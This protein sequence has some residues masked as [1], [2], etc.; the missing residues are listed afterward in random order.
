MKK[1]LF[2]VLGLGF[3]SVAFA[4]MSPEEK[5][6]LKAAQKEAKNQMSQGVKLST[7]VS[8]LY[9][10]NQAEI[11]KGEKANKELIAKNG[12]E[13]KKQSLEALELLRKAAD[14]NL[15]EEKK[16]YELYKAMEDVSKQLLNPELNLAAQNQ[17][18][19]TLTFAKAVDGVCDGSYGV[20]TKG[21]KKDEFQKVVIA[22]SE[23]QMPKLMTY[24]AYLTQFYIMGKN[25]PSA[26]AALDKYAGFAKKYPLVAEDEAVKNPQTPISQ[27]AF[28]IY[29]TAYNAKDYATCDKY[30]ELAAQYPDEQSHNFVLNSRPQ[31]YKEMGDTL[32]WVQALKEVPKMDPDSEAA[33]NAI[34]NLLSIYSHKGN[35]ALDKVADE[36]LATY[37]NSKVTNYGKGYSLF[38]QEKY[39]EAFAAFQK[40][41][42]I[43]PTYANAIFMSGTSKYRLALTNYYKH[44]D[45]KKYKTQ[46]EM[47]KAEE[48]YVKKY[49]REAKEHF[50]RYRDLKP[51]AVSDWAG[52]LENIYKN[53]GEA[54]KAKEMRALLD[55]Q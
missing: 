3:F 29:L 48:T 41:V 50:E 40:A 45:S 1:L 28:N 7:S 16:Q 49:F 13:I 39:E 18:F 27:F 44:I 30:Y 31:I 21:N 10:A 2:T 54:A 47:N 4:Q 19:D 9:G 17:P 33:E 36:L 43:D 46:A 20:I 35:A 37:P 12:A 5:A 51:E 8:T 23:L 14:S 24:Y 53:T 15:I 25:L 42:S 32:R 38:S 11:A 52:P 22:N 34:Q 26:A 55:K 6:A